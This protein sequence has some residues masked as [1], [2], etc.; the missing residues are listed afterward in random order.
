[1]TMQLLTRSKLSFAGIAMFSQ[2]TLSACGDP[3]AG[4]HGDT[5]F[6]TDNVGPGSPNVDDGFLQLAEPSEP[7]AALKGA[8]FSAQGDLD[9][10]HADCIRLEPNRLDFGN[11]SAGVYHS[12]SLS[13]VNQCAA[14]VRILG[15]DVSADSSSRFVLEAPIGRALVV[16]GHQSFELDLGLVAHLGT[17]V[18]AGRSY[19]GA[20]LI[21]RNKHSG[22]LEVVF[23]DARTLSLPVQVWTAEAELYGQVDTQTSPAP[24]FQSLDPRL[25]RPVTLDARPPFQTAAGTDGLGLSQSAN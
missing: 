13:L 24:L 1:M 12:R 20:P 3:Q 6:T 8:T 7:N 10:I 19:R 23:A 5:V 2:L 18:L 11:V 17:Q 16:P 22:R 9:P 25:D 21:L 14:S 4:V 15:A